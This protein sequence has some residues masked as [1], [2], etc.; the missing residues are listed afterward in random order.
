VLEKPEYS[1]WIIGIITAISYCTNKLGCKTSKILFVVQIIQ[2]RHFASVYYRV[3][4]DQLLAMH[5]LLEGT[6]S[7]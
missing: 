2:V 3:C 5:N 1:G 7:G 6:A 4:N